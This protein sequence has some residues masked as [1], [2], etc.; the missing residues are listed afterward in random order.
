[1]AFSAHAFGDSVEIRTFYD[2]LIATGH[3]LDVSMPLMER[4][5]DAVGRFSSTAHKNGS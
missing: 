5:A 4:Y 1:V 3:D 2:D